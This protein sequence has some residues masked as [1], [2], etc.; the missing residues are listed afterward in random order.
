MTGSLYIIV[1]ITQ[2]LA[3]KINHLTQNITTTHFI[4]LIMILLLLQKNIYSLLD[5]TVGN[6]VDSNG[7]LFRNNRP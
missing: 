2:L 6:N 3:K 1:F 4:D 5:S 7:L